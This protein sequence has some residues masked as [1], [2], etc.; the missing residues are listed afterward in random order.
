LRIALGR[1]QA[2]AGREP[3]MKWLILL[4]VVGAGAFFGYPLFNED[5]GSEC[6]ALERASVRIALSDDG[7][8]AKTQD[9][10][11]GQLFQG[12]SKGQFASVAVRNEYPN[13]PVTAACAMLYWRA[14][15]DL[16]GFREDAG[17]LRS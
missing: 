14:I 7:G 11:L 10:M 9:Q 3:E 8:K 12:L 13:V 6:D 16:K 1:W 2:A 17:K 5:A 4:I 15:L